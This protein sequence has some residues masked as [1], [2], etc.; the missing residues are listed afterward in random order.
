[1]ESKVILRSTGWYYLLNSYFNSSYDITISQLY[2]CI[3]KGLIT[4]I[5][6]IQILINAWNADP[7]HYT[8]TDF[9]QWVVD[10]YITI[11][12]FE[13]ITGLTY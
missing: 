10:G 7:Q 3:A 1:M 12:E 6:Y 11:A 13:S 9:R 8:E 2:A 4:R 5:E